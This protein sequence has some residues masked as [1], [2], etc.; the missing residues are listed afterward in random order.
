MADIFALIDHAAKEI[1]KKRSIVGM[2]SKYDKKF[3]TE[4]YYESLPDFT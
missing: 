3:E 2:P 1:R 4:R